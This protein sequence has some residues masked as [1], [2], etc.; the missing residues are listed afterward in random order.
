M[1]HET[2]TIRPGWTVDLSEPLA[3]SRLEHVVRFALEGSGFH[4]RSGDVLLVEHEHRSIRIDYATFL[5][6]A[7]DPTR[8][9]LR[10]HPLTEVMWIESLRI[11]VPLRS[12]GRGRRLVA[13]AEGVACHTGIGSINVYPL[14]AARAFWLRIGYQS[15]PRTSRVL[16][17]SLGGDGKP[18]HLGWGSAVDSAQD[19]HGV[20]KTGRCREWVRR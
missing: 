9:T 6:S 20:A 16:S 8:M 18:A 12:T 5:D 7:S 17:K 11:A 1:K 13:A 14:S 4:V 15:H 19:S 10:L 3:A 2:T